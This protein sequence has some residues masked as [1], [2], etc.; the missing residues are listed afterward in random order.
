MSYNKSQHLVDLSIWTFQNKKMSTI[1]TRTPRAQNNCFFWAQNDGEIVSKFLSQAHQQWA[2]STKPK[3]HLGRF[4]LWLL[5]TEFRGGKDRSVFAS[6]IAYLNQKSRDMSLPYWK[7]LYIEKVNHRR[8]P[9]KNGKKMRNLSVWKDHSLTSC[10]AATGAV[11][12]WSWQG[13]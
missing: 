11:F 10:T 6:K 8:S 2:T 12:R 13:Q 5:W 4:H 7:W 3:L 1:Y 9:W